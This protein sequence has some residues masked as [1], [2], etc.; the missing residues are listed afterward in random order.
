MDFALS[1]Q[2]ESIRDA[3]LKICARF[4]DDYWL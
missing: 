1:P 2:Q 3:I 4:G